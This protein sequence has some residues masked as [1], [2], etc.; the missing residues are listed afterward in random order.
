MIATPLESADERV[1]RARPLAE[2]IERA[3][4]RRVVA[5]EHLAERRLAGA[6]LADQPVD[7]ARQDV[8]RH[9]AEDP[10]PGEGD[11]DPVGS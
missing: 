3:R 8:H 5:A 7:L 6:V 2:D 1:P 10:D 9:V 11:P 4:A